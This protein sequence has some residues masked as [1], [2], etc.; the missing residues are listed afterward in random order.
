[1]FGVGLLRPIFKLSPEQIV[2]APVVVI[3][4]GAS[5]VT[6]TFI[7]LPEHPLADELIVYMAVPVLVPIVVSN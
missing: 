5:T 1:V 3:S 2:C 4:M 7:G 6:V